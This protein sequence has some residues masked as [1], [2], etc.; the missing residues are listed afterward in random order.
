[1][2][3]ILLYFSY[4]YLGDWDKIYSA[5]EKKE[6]VNWYEIEKI[7][8]Q[9]NLNY[10]T[11]VDENYPEKLKMILKP[12]FVLFYKGKF[13]LLNETNIIWIFASYI[14][15]SVGDYL[16]NK[17]EEFNK[18]NL[19]LISG[20]SSEFENHYIKRDKSDN[21]IIVKDSGINNNIIVESKVEKEIIKNGGLIIS[22]YPSYSI[23]SL[24]TWYD[25]NRI[26]I[27]LSR[28]LFLIN[29]LKEK[30]TFSIISETLEEERDVFCLGERIDSRS[31]NKILIEKGAIKI[32][33][34]EELKK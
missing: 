16:K 21:I 2:K 33:K 5:L 23:P 18:N 31:H 19:I 9:N 8:K 34:L 3:E 10:V 11:I 29:S 27:G 25:S 17:R 24:K 30:E 28:G 13:N 22:E 26:K 14:N 32:T 15:N 12:P 4:K 1:M 20:C 7:N 6:K